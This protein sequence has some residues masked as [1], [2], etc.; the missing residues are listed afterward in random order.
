MIQS[1]KISVVIPT[2]NAESQI[3]TLLDKLDRQS[4]T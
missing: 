1:M 4:V 2:L 3:L